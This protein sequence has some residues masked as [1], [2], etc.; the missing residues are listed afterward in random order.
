M[1]SLRASIRGSALAS[2]GFLWSLQSIRLY[3]DK[4][5]LHVTLE[6]LEEENE[7][8][9]QMTLTRH[10]AKN[11]IGTMSKSRHPMLATELV[12]IVYK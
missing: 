11:A 1:N 9:F 10:E 12:D 6:P 5:S 2:R 7:G 3:G 4:G 8:I